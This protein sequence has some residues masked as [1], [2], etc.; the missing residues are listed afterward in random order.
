MMNSFNNLKKLDPKKLNFE[1]DEPEEVNKLI[2]FYNS[3][4][5]RKSSIKYNLYIAIKS[6]FEKIL[7]KLLSLNFLKNFS[8]LRK[9]FIKLKT[10]TYLFNK[11]DKDEL[12]TFL[13]GKTVIYKSIPQINFKEKKILI[14]KLDHIGDFLIS[15][16]ILSKIRENYIDAEIDIV[17]GSW[18]E[19]FA[20]DL[21]IFDNIYVKDYLH[22]DKKKRT[23][24]S[25]SEIFFKRKYDIY[26]NLRYGDDCKFFDNYV[27]ATKN[28]YPSSIN[29]QSKYLDKTTISE[30]YLPQ[31]LT[32]NFYFINSLASPL[33]NKKSV[34]KLS[35]YIK[36]KNISD[37]IKNLNDFILLSPTSN[38]L[39]RSMSK[40]LL[41]N[42]LKKITTSGKKIVLVGKSDYE[43]YKYIESN[44]QIYNLVNKTN[45]DEYLYLINSS[46][47]IITVNSST[48][49]F[50]SLTDKPKEVFVF[51]FGTHHPKE[52]GSIND[53]PSSF[54]F[55]KLNCSPCHLSKIQEC[56]F[57][58]E[59]KNYSEKEID[60]IIEYLNL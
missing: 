43:N 59:C 28:I 16:P 49:H 41:E 11:N 39:L 56:P 51:F 6:P 3:E 36:S 21:D 34:I 53:N 4:I 14:A 57:G 18:N 12:T 30:N 47:K 32:N 38:S 2:N 37:K 15:Q 22:A 40:N 29:N 46:S 27:S 60:E 23:K 42:I 5:N 20:K 9:A 26:L 52:W 19:K 24:L 50:S 58:L 33:T 7:N 45:L 13:V 10:S 25:K 8:F 17:V 54:I 44:D 55:S 1:G 35:N 31:G 48:S